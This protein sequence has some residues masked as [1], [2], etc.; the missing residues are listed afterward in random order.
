MKWYELVLKPRIIGITS[1]TII[2]IAAFWKVEDP[3]YIIIPVVTGICSLITDA[4]G[5]VKD[6]LNGNKPLPS[7][8][9]DA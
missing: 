3:Q 5:D 9:D 2:G 1:L 6:A 8:S 7:S 4:V